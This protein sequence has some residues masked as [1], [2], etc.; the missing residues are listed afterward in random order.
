MSNLVPTGVTVGDWRPTP[1]CVW[2]DS[3][4]VHWP[5]LSRESSSVVVS[6]GLLPTTPELPPTVRTR[7]PSLAPLVLKYADAPRPRPMLSGG[8]TLHVPLSGSKNCVTLLNAVSVPPPKATASC[9]VCL[10]KT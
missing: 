9:G 5:A 3:D 2:A 7:S 10:R 8:P 1:A 4:Q 6:K